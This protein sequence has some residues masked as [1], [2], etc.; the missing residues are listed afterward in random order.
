MS[1][2]YGTRLHG[3]SIKNGKKLYVI[4]QLTDKERKLGFIEKEKDL[5]FGPVF[6]KVWTL[7]N[8]EI[9]HHIST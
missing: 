4:S 7:E 9:Y 3:Y 2:D 8:G 6:M 5:K 1:E